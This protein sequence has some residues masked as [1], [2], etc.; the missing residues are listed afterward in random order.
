[1]TISTVRSIKERILHACIFE[2]FAILFTMLIGILLLNKP[3]NSMGV[4]SVLISITALLL[5]II[6]NWIFDKLFPFVN[7]N[8]PVHIRI[9]HAIGF[10]ATLVIFTI[11]LIAYILKMTFI[12]AFMFELGLLI[13][14]FFYTYIYNW[15]YDQIRKKI[16]A[17][18]RQ[19]RE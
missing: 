3:I 10:E 18:Y 6:F 15:S 7:G 5:N 12:D 19:K 13:F 2:F 14:F 16:V 9:L 17:R 8:R 1:M 11:P 4:V